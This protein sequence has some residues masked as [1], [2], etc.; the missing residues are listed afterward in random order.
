MIFNISNCNE[1]CIKE[2]PAFYSSELL[3]ADGFGT[4]T[5]TDGSK[6][7][8]Y[9]EKPLYIFSKDTKPGDTK[10]HGVNEVWFLATFSK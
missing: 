7:S 6:Q 4:I 3:T 2:W 8:T 1:E 5:R 9:L 10:G